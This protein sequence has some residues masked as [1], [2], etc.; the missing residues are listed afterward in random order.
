MSAP[1][2]FVCLTC[3]NTSNAGL[4]GHVRRY[5]DKCVRGYM[6][7]VMN[8]Q[9]RLRVRKACVVCKKR[10]VKCDGETPCSN[11]IK[12]KQECH[13][14]YT[15]L[16]KRSRYSKNG[17][18]E[19]VEFLS[20]AGKVERKS[21]KTVD[22]FAS[23]PAV[24][25]AFPFGIPSGSSTKTHE[26]IVD[27]FERA[28]NASSHHNR[29]PWQSFSSDKYR[30]H[31]RYQNLLPYYLGG[32]L[33][34][35]LPK[36]SILN[37]NLEQP[38]IQNY[39]W[40][41]CGG[42][43]LRHD[44][45]INR[46]KHSPMDPTTIFNFEDPV[47][48][49]VIDKLLKYF[50]NEINPFLSIVH[51][52]MF[53][54]QF[55]NRFLN[56]SKQ[57]NSTAKLFLSILYLLLAISLRFTEGLLRETDVPA[58]YTFTAE[59]AH[60]LG[61]IS[62]EELMFQYAYSIVTKLTFE[63]ES[64]ELIQSWLLISFYFRTSYRQTACWNALSQAVSMCNG[65][66]LY[67]NRFPK[68]HS[69]YDENRAWHCFWA[70]FIMDKLITFQMGRYYQMSLPVSHMATPGNWQEN[71]V[72]EDRSSEGYVFG[73][74][75]AVENHEPAI[76]GKD[77]W[78]H[79][80]TIQLFQ[81]SLIIMNCQM[82]NGEEL[83]LEESLDIRSQLD[84]WHQKYVIE[85]K[86]HKTWRKLCQ[87]QPFISYLDV[88]LTFETRGLFYLINRPS[89]RYEMIF[90][91]DTVATMNHC[92][93][94]T[95][96][97]RQIFEKSLI[98]VP[99]WLNL[100]QLFTVSV[101]CI[102]MIHSGLQSEYS[103]TFLAQCMDI[104]DCLSNLNPKN[105]PQMLA[106]CLWCLRMLNHMC[107]MR[108]V[109]SAT[110]LEMLVGTTPG[111]SG[112]NKNRFSQ[113]GKVGEE[114]EEDADDNELETSEEQDYDPQEQIADN[115]ISNTPSSISKQNGRL[116]VNISTETGGAQPQ[117]QSKSGEGSMNV[118]IAQQKINSLSTDANSTEF[119]DESLFSYL[120][121]FDQGF[122]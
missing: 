55:K 106:E 39:G 61:E 10:K 97:M 71:K 56:Q 45:N 13:Y 69:K 84:E 105:P 83:S 96:I 99:W 119:I 86:I 98:F 19:Q 40:N 14:D 79:P 92:Q 121:W 70:C 78:F 28:N 49:S 110:H 117:F 103:R 73:D 42:H 68:E 22:G 82:K 60:V 44:E 62:R 36:Q 4:D 91:L 93:Q 95:N 50:F 116:P 63:W 74:S 31:R 64:F 104:F 3:S 67:L 25:M 122:I 32:S 89:N 111:D 43:F 114:D 9:G 58:E 23:P 17:S 12:H 20:G 52:P 34:A 113:F 1:K 37:Y 59:E 5:S 101:I 81:L 66:S 15:T 6:M 26:N 108:L 53:W 41:L 2:T 27:T 48:L 57:K 46:L 120:Q 38:R 88:R 90:P 75:P 8:S 47:H 51:E 54:E 29:C 109:S 85:T 115:D 107:C 33:L 100:S 80:E 24:Q 72:D 11:C 21:A 87:I 16:K 7:D 118:N 76:N 65:M 77:D 112:P 18:L 35:E 30:F 94:S 102:A